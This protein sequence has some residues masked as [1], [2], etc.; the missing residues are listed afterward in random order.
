MKQ[1]SKTSEL[2]AKPEV[3]AGE[4]KQSRELF[5]ILFHR[6][7]IGTYIIQNGHFRLVNRQ[8]AYILGY[9]EDELIGRPSLGFVLAEDR[10][11]VRENAVRMLKAGCSLGYEFRIIT[12]QANI[13]WVMETVAP[14]HYQRKRATLGSLVDVTERKQ[15]EE[16]LK[17]ITVEMQRSNTELEQFAYV[18][19]HDLQEPLR[20]VSSYTQLLAKRY[21]NKLDSDADEFIAYAVDGAKRM[22]TLLHSLLDYSRV[23][24]RGKPFGLVNCEHVVEQAVANLKIAIEESGASVSYDVLPTVMGDEGQLVQLFQNLIGNAIKFRGEEPPKV[25]IWAG[26]RD[27]VVTFS[28]ND[29]GIG[30]NPQHSQSIF[31]IFRRLHTREEYPGTGMG[32][33][34]CKKIAERHG[35]HISVQSQPGQG[36]TFHFSVDMAGGES[37]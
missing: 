36:S 16:R 9:E 32:L 23:G 37:A 14:V 12:K 18:I 2:I 33:A 8:L 3:M 5:R 6:S 19:S 7:P 4:I 20:M 1:M 11:A 29:N 21:S 27:S 30:I 22:Q 24:T 17:Q 28:V 26:R 15:V 25:H 31:E 34:I 13:K 35:G 10:D